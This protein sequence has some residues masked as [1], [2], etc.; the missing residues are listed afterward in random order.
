MD[1]AIQF[2]QVNHTY[3]AGTPFSHKALH[4]VNV[5]IP[6]NKVTAIIGHTGSGK[7]TLIQH[8]NALVRPTSGTVELFGESVTASSEHESLK[9]LRKKVGVVFQFPESQ[10][11]EETVLKDVMF[12]PLNFDVTEEVAEQIARKQLKLV[13]IPEYLHQRSPF[14][15]SG[16]QMRRVAI[17]GVLALEPDVL[18]LDEPTAGLDPLGHQQMMEMFMDLHRQQGTTLIMVT[19]QM[20]DV[21][22]YADCVIVM[23]AGTVVRTGTPRE[24]FADE[25]WLKERHLDLPT[26]VNYLHQLELRSNRPVKYDQI[27]L[28]GEELTAIIDDYLKSSGEESHVQ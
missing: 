9:W 17:A 21:A 16:G 5:T 26:P 14:E 24:I 20:D 2:K 8:L 28:T 27:P 7:S 18:V 4:N 23:E 22:A 25:A 3:N 15:L 11:F 10:L 12:G 6:V 19:H 1:R 13:G